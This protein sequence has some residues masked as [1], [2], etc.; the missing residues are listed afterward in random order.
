LRGDTTKNSIAF[1]HKTSFAM[2]NISL[3]RIHARQV[4]FFIQQLA[5]SA[6]RTSTIHRRDKMALPASERLA[7]LIT[8]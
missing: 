2:Q 3:R 7:Y 4:L 5:P 8:A 1:R 6:R